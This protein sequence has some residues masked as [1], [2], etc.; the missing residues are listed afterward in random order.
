VEEL[1]PALVT[2]RIKG[3]FARNRRTGRESGDL[4][5]GDGRTVVGEIPLAPGANDIELRIEG[6]T[7]IA[8]LFRFRVYSASRELVGVPADVAVSPE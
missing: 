3:V 5:A 1:L 8:G 4:L 6:K 7:G 2:R